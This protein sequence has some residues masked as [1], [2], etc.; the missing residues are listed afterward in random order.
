MTSDKK[1]ID[2]F[3]P[4]KDNPEWSE[5][6]LQKLVLQMRFLKN[7]VSSRNAPLVALQAP[8]QK[9]LYLFALIK[10]WWSISNRAV[11]TGKHASMKH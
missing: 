5:K 1:K 9:F 2:P 3:T 7:W 11:K 8:T 10:K 6:I 4:D